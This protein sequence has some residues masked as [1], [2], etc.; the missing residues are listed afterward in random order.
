L[1]FNYLWFNN[2]KRRYLIENSENES[3]YLTELLPENDNDFL[4]ATVYYKVRDDVLS[5]IRKSAYETKDRE[6]FVN[7][8]LKDSNDVEELLEKQ[9]ELIEDKTIDE[10]NDKIT[11]EGNIESSLNELENFQMNLI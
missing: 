6:S 3:E 7:F 1:E 5:R 9:N 11:A 2:F 8:E 10:A 4:N